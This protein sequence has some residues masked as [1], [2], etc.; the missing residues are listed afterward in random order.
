MIN[1]VPRN[2]CSWT[3]IKE[4]LDPAWSYVVIETTA[5]TPCA[6]V[7]RA[8]TA[9]LA[10]Y[11]ADIRQ[12]EICRETS[13]GHLLILVQIAP[14]QTEALKRKLLDHTLP[15]SVTVYFYDHTPGGN[16]P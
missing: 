14:A 5:A 10:G 9:L 4:R 7:F 16:E 6:H 1:A 3:Q 8:V 15:P 11:A 2:A 12:Q 13:S